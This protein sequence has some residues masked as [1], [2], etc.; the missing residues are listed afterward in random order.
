MRR[1][2]LGLTL[3]LASASAAAQPPCIPLD[4]LER[5]AR[6]EHGETRA[7]ESAETR[8]M[9]IVLWLAEES[10]SWTLAVV[11]RQLACIIGA[12]KESTRHAPE[13]IP[14]PVKGG[15]GPLIPS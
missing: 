3:A 15:T 8:G 7:W 9:Q 11:R 2:L 12:G 6:D 13:S 1:I 14:A 4:V 10:G 5:A